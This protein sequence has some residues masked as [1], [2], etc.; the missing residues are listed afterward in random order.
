MV[1]DMVSAK[2]PHPLLRVRSRGSGDDD[3][4]R[5]LPR[6]LNGDRPNPA[7]ATDD[8]N[9]RSCT[10]DGLHDVQAVEHRLPGCQR[11]QR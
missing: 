8:E 6:Y 4:I 5:A 2:P 11:R 10:G 3:E 7:R 1:D 9:R